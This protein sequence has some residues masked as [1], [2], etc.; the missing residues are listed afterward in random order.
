[1]GA[2]VAEGSAV[3]NGEASGSGAANVGSVATGAGVS[4]SGAGVAGTGVAEAD[5]GATALVT[6]NSGI[7][8]CTV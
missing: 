6:R 7:D 4:A 3:E 5:A 2:T 8:F 1:M